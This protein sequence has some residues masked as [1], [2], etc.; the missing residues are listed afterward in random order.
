MIKIRKVINDYLKTLHSQVYYQQPPEDAS[1]PY[2]VFDFPQSL[3]DGEGLE[4]ITVDIDGWDAPKNGDT[5][6][7]ENLMTNVNALDKNVLVQDGL[8]AT[9]YLENRLSLTDDD[10]RIRRRKYIYQARVFERS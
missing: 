5:T 7:L 8:R 1:Y 2:L 3:P 9:F 10:K 6:V 4:V